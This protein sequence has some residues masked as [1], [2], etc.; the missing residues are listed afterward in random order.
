MAVTVK[1]EHKSKPNPDL[2]KPFRTSH[3]NGDIVKGFN[4]LE[5][6]QEDAAVR[7]ARAKTM[8]LSVTYRAHAKDD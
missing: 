6:A 5:S 2:F 7:N 1:P 4:D 3:P 8:G